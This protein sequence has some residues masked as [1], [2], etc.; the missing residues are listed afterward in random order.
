MIDPDRSHFTDLLKRRFGIEIGPDKGYLLDARL[1]GPAERLG[2]DGVGALLAA[3][4]AA[5]AGAAAEAA[6]E[7]MTTNETLFFRDAAPFAALAEMLR[8]AARG[9]PGAPFRIWSAA[10]ATG[11]EAWSIVMTAL[12]TQPAPPVEVL[13]TDVSARCLE[14]AERGVY[15]AFEMQRGVSDARRERHFDRVEAGW[16]VKPRLR[17]PV[18]WRRHNLMEPLRHPHRFDVI[19]CRNVLIYFD[20]GTRAAVLARLADQLAPG[21]A[22]ILGGAE[23]PLG[24]TTRFRPKPGAPGVHLRDDAASPSSAAAA[25]GPTA[26]HWS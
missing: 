23:T 14:V 10:C 25:P 7:A 15:G 13:A 20:T 4:R 21:G 8:E 19:F 12:E 5:P 3:V 11:Q 24:V 18:R 1:Q 6:L 22:L 26:P 16:S 17:E 2:L 9:R